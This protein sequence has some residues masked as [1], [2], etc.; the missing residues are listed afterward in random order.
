MRQ[1]R[2]WK[3]LWQRSLT[4]SHKRTSMEPFKSCWNGTT[5]ALQSEEITLKGTRVSCV[6]YQWK[7]PYKKSLETYRMHLIYIYI[8]I[9]IYI[10]NEID[11]LMFLSIYIYIYICIKLWLY[12]V[13][14]S[15]VRVAI[16]LWKAKIFSWPMTTGRVLCLIWDNVLMTNNYSGSCSILHSRPLPRW[17]ATSTRYHFLSPKKV[18]GICI[19]LHQFL[20]GI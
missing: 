5:S 17:V 12:F 9:Y 20:S 1:L 7:C 3:R 14:L 10:M 2:R 13:F 8:Y 11:T 4:C 19:Y 16:L 15:T 6:Y 18:I